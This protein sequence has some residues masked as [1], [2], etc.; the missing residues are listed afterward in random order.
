MQATG[1]VRRIDDLG[2]IVIPREIRRSLGVKENDPLEMF[3]TSDKDGL[4]LVPYRWG[5]KNDL[6][7][8]ETK[9]SEEVCG[10]DLSNARQAFKTLYKILANNGLE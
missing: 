3:L 1:I 7:A 10:A 4:I 2:R 9:M 8:L 5:I 6:E